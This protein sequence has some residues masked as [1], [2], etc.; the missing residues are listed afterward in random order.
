MI[1]AMTKKKKNPIAQAMVAL[2]NK[3]LSPAERKTIASNAA[4]ARW[5]QQ[6]EAEAK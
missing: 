3:K 2:R 6:R 4:K 5:A 1:I